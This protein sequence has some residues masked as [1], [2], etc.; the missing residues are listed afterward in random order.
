MNMIIFFSILIIF[1]IL[2]MV[3]FNIKEN[4]VNREAE[5]FKSL[6]E[7]KYKILSLDPRSFEFF[8]ADLFKAL[9][10]SCKVTKSSKDGGKDIIALSPQG[11]FYIEAKHYKGT[12]GRPIAQ[13]LQG[14]CCE[15]SNI[16]GIIATSGHFS[17]D[18][19]DYCKK[20]G[21]QTYDLNGLLS[22]AD[23]AGYIRE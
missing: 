5:K 10:Y 2:Y 4:Q 12:V 11:K 20:V 15:G 1:Q 9:G 19:L 17:E 22:L 16:K 3:A 6:Q 13:K 8:L 21:I 14:A 23:K 18:C 7:L